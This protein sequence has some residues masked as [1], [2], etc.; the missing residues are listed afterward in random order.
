MSDS[1][2]DVQQAIAVSPTPAAEFKQPPRGRQRGVS[3]R[4]PDTIQRSLVEDVDR[5]GLPSSSRQY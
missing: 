4:L 5:E 3:F 2:V 1:L